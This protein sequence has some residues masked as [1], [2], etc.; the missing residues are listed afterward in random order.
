[1]SDWPPSR[2]N[3]SFI[4]HS[5]AEQVFLDAWQSGRLAHAWLICGVRGIGKATL[6]YRFARFLLDQKTAESGETSLFGDAPP[7]PSLNMAVDHPVFRQVAA[8]GC[9]D[10]KVVERGYADDKKSK[11]RSEI[12]VDDVRDIGHFLSMTPAGGG[13]R[14]VVIDA[15][16][17]MNRNAANAVLKVLEEPPRQAILLLVAHAPGRLLPTIRSRCRRLMLSP[18]A[19]SEVLTLLQGHVPNL[20]EDETRLLVRLAEGSIGKAL[21]LVEG[22]GVGLLREIFSLLEGVGDASTIPALHAFADR[23]VRDG[24]GGNFRMAV[25]LLRWWL[26]RMIRGTI[27]SPADELILG[28]TALLHRFQNAAGLDQWGDVWEK[29]MTLLNRTEGLNLD[30]KQS[31]LSLFFMIGRLVRS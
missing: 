9:A 27:L 20:T 18:L 6:A 28:E 16:D 7:P 19:D 1:M 21:S 10:L 30:R 14:V 8:L 22:G 5:A 3:P 17:E 25:E 2:E 24:T 13:W 29:S 15:A 12:V 11:L 31:L 26:A 4:G 23:L